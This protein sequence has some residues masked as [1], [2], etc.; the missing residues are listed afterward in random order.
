[1]LGELETGLK[2]CKFRGADGNVAEHTLSVHIGEKGE[3]MSLRIWSGSNA[4]QRRNK[5]TY[6]SKRGLLRVQTARS[7]EDD[8]ASDV[9]KGRVAVQQQSS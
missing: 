8:V 6:K 1:M 9:G 4:N 2:V 7:M 3:D 5:L